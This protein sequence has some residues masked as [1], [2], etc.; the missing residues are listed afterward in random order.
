MDPYMQTVRAEVPLASAL[1]LAA[2]W[3]RM[4]DLSRAHLYV[5]GLTAAV[6]FVG[7]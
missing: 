2:A 1:D 3:Q 7:P 6:T 4:R 5:P